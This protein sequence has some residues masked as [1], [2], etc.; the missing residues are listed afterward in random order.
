MCVLKNQ[1]TEIS[2]SLC[3]LTSVTL[4]PRLLNFERDATLLLENGSK[5]HE[6]LRKNNTTTTTT[7]TN[8]MKTFVLGPSYGFLCL[9]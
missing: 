2:Y 9:K 3:G 6:N 1:K 5:K 8:H 7:T 4:L